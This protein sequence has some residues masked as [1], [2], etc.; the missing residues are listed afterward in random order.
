MPAASENGVTHRPPRLRSFVP[1]IGHPKLIILTVNI[2]LD[3][4]R[5]I[6]T[7]YRDCCPALMGGI[8][9]A[10]RPLFKQGN[11]GKRIMELRRI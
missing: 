5:D 2:Q 6:K 9:N 7:T 4:V 1:L 8:W 3:L 11:G 10:F